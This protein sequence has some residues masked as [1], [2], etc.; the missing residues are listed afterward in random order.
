M[1]RITLLFGA[2]AVLVMGLFF[3]DDAG[4]H[5][6]ACFVLLWMGLAVK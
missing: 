3:S 1:N 4:P 5:L 2:A 6:S